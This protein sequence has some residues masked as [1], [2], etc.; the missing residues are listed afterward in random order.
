MSRKELDEFIESMNT[1]QFAEVQKFFD[2]I[3]KLRHTIKVVNPNTKVE[4]EMVL[5]GLQSFLG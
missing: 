4:N 1:D 3:P 2:G 5:E